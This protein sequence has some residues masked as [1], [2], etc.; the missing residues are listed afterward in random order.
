MDNPENRV[1]S[2]LQHEKKRMEILQLTTK[3]HTSMTTNEAYQY[4]E[5]NLRSLAEQDQ[6]EYRAVNFDGRTKTGTLQEIADWIG[7]EITID[8]S[9]HTGLYVA[10]RTASDGTREYWTGWSV[11]RE[12]ETAC[13]AGGLVSE[14]RADTKILAREAQKRDPD[15]GWEIREIVLL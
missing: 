4:L 15:G 5:R 14:L 12:I 3:H 1:P 10:T 11:T 2:G 8:D 7:E 9:I 13:I 6:N